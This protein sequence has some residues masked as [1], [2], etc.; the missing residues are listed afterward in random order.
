MS[1]YDDYEQDYTVI[2][3][4]RIFTIVIASFSTLFPLS[5][6][7][8]LI[9]RYNTLVR[10]K[11][12]IHYV[13]MIAIADTMTA[14]A[15]AFGFPEPGPL[16]TAQG[17]LLIFFSRMSWFFTDVLIF[18]LFYIVVFKKYFLNVKYMHCIVW[19]VNIMLQILPYTTGTRYGQDDGE[20]PNGIT[21]EICN[22]GKGTG[23]NKTA[24]KWLQYAYNIELLISFGIIITL[25][26]IVTIYCLYMKNT[27]TSHVYLAQRI[28]E[29]W[30]IVV[31]YPCAMLIAW[32]P[33]MIFARYN[34][35]LDNSG[36]KLPHHIFVIGDY[37]Q[38]INAL[39]G[40]LLALIFYTKT[41]EA[42]R[43]WMYNLRCILYVLKDI[44][45]DDRSTCSS[46]ISIEDSQIAASRLNRAQSGL[47]LQLWGASR[48]KQVKSPIDIQ[49]EEVNPI[50][51][52][53][54]ISEGL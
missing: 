7:V 45:V 42:R 50:S 44:D 12:L 14:L 9:Q 28:R 34:I 4:A 49:D 40:P 2:N 11:S 38:A 48:S 6:V 30:S 26:I 22:L 25:S 41:L 52:V 15:I 5:V 29:S 51:N 37:L 17:F 54:R 20:Q 13:M 8:I 23:S 1:H 16:C 33:G 43:A 10:G 46:I 31:L 18:Q 39:Y 32:M 3:N 19:S 24:G 47:S 35:Y 27:K 53:V 36:K 21:Y